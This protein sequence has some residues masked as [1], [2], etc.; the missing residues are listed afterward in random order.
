MRRF[1]AQLEG[2]E[3]L[4]SSCVDWQRDFRGSFPGLRFC[5]GYFFKVSVN[6]VSYHATDDAVKGSLYQSKRT[7]RVSPVLLEL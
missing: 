4:A 5:I 6:V 3:V 1:K 2:V 7:R